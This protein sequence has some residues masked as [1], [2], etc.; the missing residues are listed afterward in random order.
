[1]VWYEKFAEKG[2]EK[3]IS[4]KTLKA[5]KKEL[6]KEGRYEEAQYLDREVMPHMDQQFR[7]PEV[8]EEIRNMANEIENDTKESIK[9][10]EEAQEIVDQYE[11]AASYM[12][13]EEYAEEEDGDMTPPMDMEAGDNMPPEF[14]VPEDENSYQTEPP[15]QEEYINS[16]EQTDIPEGMEHTLEMSEAENTEDQEMPE[17]LAEEMDMAP[18]YEEEETQNLAIAEEQYEQEEE[19]Q[20]G[21][22]T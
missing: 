6:E 12:P 11:E 18:A 10:D 13:E 15:D 5:Q 8:L 19:E 20:G 16:L 1:M 9:T 7:N 22:K 21:K 14:D 2:I 4:C 3:R 17:D